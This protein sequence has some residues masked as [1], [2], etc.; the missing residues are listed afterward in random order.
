MQRDAAS[1]GGQLEEGRSMRR[2]ALHD[3]QWDGI[4]NFLP[5]IFLAGVQ[6]ASMVFEYERIRVW[7]ERMGL[8][9][10]VIAAGPWCEEHD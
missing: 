10:G 8:C 5:K 7:Q 3:D 6:L 2:F 9:K 1:A 4:K